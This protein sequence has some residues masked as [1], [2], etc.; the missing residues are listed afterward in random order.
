MIA[1]EVETHLLR[2]AQE[3]LTNALT[4]AQASTIQI[5]LTFGTQAVELCVRDDGQ[6]FEPTAVRGNGFGLVSMQERADCING[7]VTLTS[8]PGCGTVVLIAAPAKSN[9]PIR[10]S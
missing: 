9:A 3:A 7:E 8:Q 5:E 2:I 4:H 1:P 6:G 10:R